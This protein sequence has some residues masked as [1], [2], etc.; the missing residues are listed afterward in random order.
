MF[1][2]LSKIVSISDGNLLFIIFKRTEH[3]IPNLSSNHS[4]ARS[5]KAAKPP[6]RQEFLCALASLRE[7]FTVLLDLD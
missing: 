2:T 6:S 5:A 7:N 3:N 1:R 4:D